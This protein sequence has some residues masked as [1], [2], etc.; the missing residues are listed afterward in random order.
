VRGDH[1]RAA[2]T[3]EEIHAVLDAYFNGLNTEDWQGLEALMCEDAKLW[4]PGADRHGAAAV[5]AYFRDALAPYPDHRDEPGRRFVEGSTAVVEIRFIGRMATGAP[6]AFDAVDV[7]DLRDGRIARLTSWYDSHEVRR[8]LAAGQAHGNDETAARA[9]FTLAA[10]SLRGRSVAALGGR[11]HGEIPAALSLPATVIEVSGELRAEQLPSQVHGRALLLRGAA[12]IPP[13]LVAGAAAVAT[14]GTL[15][16]SGVPLAGTG[17]E[18]SG[19]A[20][21]DGLLVSSPDG[22]GLAHAVLLR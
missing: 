16:A 19:V 4:A 11:W 10:A 3:H 17:F 7:F 12:S 15:A 13:E 6:M 21:G 2:V 14:D 18:L 20:A 22:S 8:A 1:R 5:A 9:A